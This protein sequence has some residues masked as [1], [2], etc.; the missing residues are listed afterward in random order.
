MARYKPADFSQGQFI[1][2]SF[3]KQILPGGFERAGHFVIN[4]KLDFSILDE[5]HTNDDAGARPT[6]RG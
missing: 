3:E 1:P 5:A 2:I 6:T 4:E